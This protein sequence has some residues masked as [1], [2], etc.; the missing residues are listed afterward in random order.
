MRLMNFEPFI[1]YEAVTPEM[2]QELYGAL[3]EHRDLVQE[4]LSDEEPD[5]EKCARLLEA[6]HRGQN[7]FHAI[8]E[9]LWT[10]PVMVHIAG[11]VQHET[12]ED[13]DEHAFQRCTRCASVLNHFHGHYLVLDPETG[14]RQMTEE[15]VPWWSE[16]TIVAKHTQSDTGNVGMYPIDADRE[17]EK[18]ERVCADL[19]GLG[20]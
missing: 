19:T 6:A 3:H 12:D 7:C 15:D 20:T 16:G 17:L 14:P 11:P 8:I 2:A 18:H 13:G 9:A 4:F 1:D 10:T 5:V